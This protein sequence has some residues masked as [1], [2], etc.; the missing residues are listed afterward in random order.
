M[1]LRTS[2]PLQILYPHTSSISLSPNPINQSMLL[3][4]GRCSQNAICLAFLACLYVL[5]E[6]NLRTSKAHGVLLLRLPNHVERIFPLMVGRSAGQPTSQSSRQLII[7]YAQTITLQEHTPAK[8][9]SNKPNICA[10]QGTE[11]GRPTDRHATSSYQKTSTKQH[12]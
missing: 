8:F 5:I 10:S 1:H 12:R 2:W 4:S 7:H 9:C 3:Q 6:F 11:A